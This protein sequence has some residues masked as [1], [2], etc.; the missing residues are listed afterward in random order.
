MSKFSLILL[1]ILAISA[2]TRAADKEEG[3][4]FV[5]IFNR[6]HKDPGP[7]VKARANV[8]TDYIEQKL[9]HFDE[10][11]TRTWQMVSSAKD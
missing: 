11:E 9:D 4:A 10:S 2:L 5:N 1:A 8:V 7:E 3:E 6:L